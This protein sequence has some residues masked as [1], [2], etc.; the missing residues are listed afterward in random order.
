[1]DCLK[2]ERIGMIRGLRVD[3]IGIRRVGHSG[4]KRLK[5]RVKIISG[6]IRFIRLL[7]LYKNGVR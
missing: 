1:M 2:E 7:M 3:L 5:I 6:G 4:F